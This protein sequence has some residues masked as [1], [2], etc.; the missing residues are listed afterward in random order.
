MDL[1]K[2]EGFNPLFLFGKFIKNLT[3]NKVVLHSR[4]LKENNFDP[5]TI[6][7]EYIRGKFNSGI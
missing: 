3:L 2:R 5:F 4:L 7:F 1:L 6:D